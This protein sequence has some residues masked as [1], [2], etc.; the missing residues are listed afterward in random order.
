MVSILKRR[1][2]VFDEYAVLGWYIVHHKLVVTII[3]DRFEFFCQVMTLL[4]VRGFDIH[5][6]KYGDTFL[7]WLSD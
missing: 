4:L 6:Y 2:R 1:L 5:R 3:F 7:K